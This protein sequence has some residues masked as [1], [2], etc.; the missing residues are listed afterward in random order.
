MKYKTSPCDVIILYLSC[1][2][3]ASRAREKTA[4]ED[5]SV[6]SI[7]KRIRKDIL[8]DAKRVNLT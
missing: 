3:K 6:P 7:M 5:L 1:Y 4:K 8:K 2:S